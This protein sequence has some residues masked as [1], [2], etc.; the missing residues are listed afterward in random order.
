MSILSLVGNPN[1]ILRRSDERNREK[2]YR[3]ETQNFSWQEGVLWRG[4]SLQGMDQTIFAPPT[5]FE[6]NPDDVL[7]GAQFK[8]IIGIT[9]DASGAP[10][11]SCTV[12]GFL[13]SDDSYQGQCTSDAGGY[14]EFCT[15]QTGAHYLVAYRTGSPDVT[16]ATANTLIPV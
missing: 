12:Q 11:G 15:K 13:T 1:T 5:R 4:S 2:E 3:S 8:K 7:G 16:G 6:N 14:F 9:R 10:L